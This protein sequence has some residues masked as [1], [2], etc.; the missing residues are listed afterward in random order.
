MKKFLSFSILAAAALTMTPA[1]NAQEA[2]YNY[3]NIP[4]VKDIYTHSWRDNWYIQLGAGA[5]M[6][7]F[8]KNGDASN[9]QMKKTTALYEA[10]VGHWFSPYFGFRFRGQGGAM[11][12]ENSDQWHKGKY[13]NLNLEITWD[14]FNSLCGVNDH[15]VFSIIPYL[16]VGGSYAWDYSVAGNIL[17]N[18]GKVMEHQG[19]VNTNLGLQFRFRCSKRVDLYVDARLTGTADNIN[20]IAWKTGLDPIFSM[21]GVCKSTSAKKAVT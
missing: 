11:H 18:D 7:I 19:V 1:V 14:M 13:A 15:R 3:T 8:E 10:G 5:Q 21:T 17:D 2:D 9:F 20:N 4:P 6:P 12:W 16:G